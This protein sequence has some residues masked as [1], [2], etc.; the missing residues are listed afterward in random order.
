M[1]RPRL[2]FCDATLPLSSVL[3]LPSEHKTMQL[4]GM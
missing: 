3:L 2:S 4:G 1:A